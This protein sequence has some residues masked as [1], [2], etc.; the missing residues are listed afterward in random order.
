ASAVPTSSASASTPTGDTHLVGN[1]SNAE[2]QQAVNDNIK[3]FDAC[4]TLGADKQGKF[5]ATIT[6]KVTVGPLGTVKDASL[7]KSTSKNTK[8]NTCVVDAF[9]KVKFP[10]PR[11]G[12][13]IITYPMTFGGE[14]VVKK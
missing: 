7:V 3:L 6:I 10:Q 4:Y 11:G 12:A 2:I 13:A 5:E 9:K 14:V 8:V 1:L